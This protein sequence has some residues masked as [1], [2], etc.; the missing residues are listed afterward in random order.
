MDTEVTTLVKKLAA[1]ESSSR[2]DWISDGMYLAAATASSAGEEL[3]VRWFCGAFDA[4]KRQRL[5]HWLT[6]TV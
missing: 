1:E 5:L 6:M 3:R 4:E 2:F